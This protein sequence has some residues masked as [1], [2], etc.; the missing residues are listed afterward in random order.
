MKMLIKI[1]GVS[2][3]FFLFSVTNAQHTVGDTAILYVGEYL[4]D[5]DTR[6]IYILDIENTAEPI[7]I[8]TVNQHGSA[9]GWSPD[10]RYVFIVNYDADDNR[11]LMVYDVNADTAEVMSSNLYDNECAIPVYWSPDGHYMAF[12]Q[13]VGDEVVT[14]LW[15]SAEDTISTI[16]GVRAESIYY[17]VWSPDGRYLALPDANSTAYGGTF[18]WDTVTQSTITTFNSDTYLN[19]EFIWSADARYF[20]YAENS[21]VIIYNPTDAT[22]VSV[23]GNE[24]GDVSPD[25]R[26][27]VYFQRN[28]SYGEA[29][30]MYLYD[31]QT[32]Q[33]ILVSEIA[34]VFGTTWSPDSHTVAFITRHAEYQNGL[35]LYDVTTGETV[36]ILPPAPLVRYSFWSATSQYIAVVYSD[37][38]RKEEAGELAI[39]NR[40]TGILQHFDYDIPNLYYAYPIYWSPVGDYLVIDTNNVG[41][42]LF[43]AAANNAIELDENTP[44]IIPDWSADG[45]HL[46]FAGY[47]GN[48]WNIQLYAMAEQAAVSLSP[49]AMDWNSFIGWRGTN[50]NSSLIYCGEG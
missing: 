40:E 24:I 26:Y 13:D 48:S 45:Q 28:D 12:Q 43:D 29:A 6:P 30:S 2:F 4:D 44:W 22:Q 21:E 46:V 7:Q 33:E 38:G 35:S 10:G 36:E 39:Y 9:T 49:D 17:D 42:V 14:S 41:Q 50:R 47:D 5:S 37:D 34:S 1:I 27:V 3:V 16:E 32:Q 8:G 31:M 23:T 19:R 11:V 20:V 15:D 25:G 18:I